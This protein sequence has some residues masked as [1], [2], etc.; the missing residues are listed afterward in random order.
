MKH[1]YEVLIDA[2]VETVW[3]ILDDVDSMKKWQ[4]SLESITH[5]SGEPGQPGAV[6]EL[7]YD[8]NGR[9]VT[10]I[11]TVTERRDLQFMALKFESSMGD[12]VVVN[13]FEDIDGKQTRWK[14]YSNFT[15]KGF[16]RWISLFF[17][18]SIRRSNEEMLHNFKL[19][20]ETEQA[21]AS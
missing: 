17:G 9:K 13:H 19:L 18:G 2:D 16:F 12:T 3:K 21:Q 14:M 8:E 7:V 10:M 1:H 5:K 11:E 15:F 20:A 6:S 4:P